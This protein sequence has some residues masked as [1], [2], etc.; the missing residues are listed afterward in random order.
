MAL[1]NCPLSL[2]PIM[3]Y[4]GNNTTC[5]RVQY[6]SG[7]QSSMF[8]YCETENDWSSTST[9]LLIAPMGLAPNGVGETSQ[10]FISSTHSD[11]ETWSF[12]G[13]SQQEGSSNNLYKTVLKGLDPKQLLQ[14]NKESL[15]IYLPI[16]MPTN[17]P[18]GGHKPNWEVPGELLIII[19]KY[20]QFLH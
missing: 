1:A 8:P 18:C 15:F 3:R 13:H 14:N 19:T 20:S 11:G 6:A 2:R 17:L 7:R 4:L 9:L 5:N 10:K 12:Q 16:R